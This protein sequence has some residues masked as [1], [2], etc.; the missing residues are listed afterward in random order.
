MKAAAYRK[1]VAGKVSPPKTSKAGIRRNMRTRKL[2]NIGHG[3]IGFC[4]EVGELQQGL[5]AY[6][7]GASQ[8]RDDMKVNAREEMGDIG[9]Y[10]I[11]IL[12][13]ELK[14]KVPTTGKK[15]KL[16]GTI[17]ENIM[18]LDGLAT[19]ALDVHKKAYYDRDYD[20]VRLA[21]RVTLAVTYYYGICFS[22]FG[23]PPAQILEENKAKLDA[24]YAEK[25][26]TEEAMDRDLKKEAKAVGGVKKAPAKAAVKKPIKPKD[27]LAIAAA[28]VS[29]PV[30]TAAKAALQPKA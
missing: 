17:T 28:K 9:F 12:A 2:L 8:M 26:T 6:L 21:D 22:L 14:I 30:A 23:E 3:I 19:D 16:T 7:T 11:G 10:L 1:Y 15:V 13:K 24:R 18:L 5:H 29:K 4:T 25:F 20:L 27:P